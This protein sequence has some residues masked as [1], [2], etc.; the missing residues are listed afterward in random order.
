M[1]E[2]CINTFLKG[3]VV[4]LV[5]HQIQYLKAADKILVLDQGEITHEGTFDYM[6]QSC[7]DISSFLVQES[8]VEEDEVKEENKIAHF[9]HVAATKLQAASLL[10]LFKKGRIFSGTAAAECMSIVC[11]VNFQQKPF[12]Q[13]RI[14]RKLLYLCFLC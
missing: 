11:V 7:E 9:L 2:E 1:F 12:L 4:I 14:F 13:F 3:K 8:D 5:T 10:H 6:L